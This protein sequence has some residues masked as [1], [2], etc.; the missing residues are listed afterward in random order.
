MNM[1]KLNYTVT[2]ETKPVPEQ[3]DLLFHFVTVTDHE[4]ET[5]NRREYLALTDSQPTGESQEMCV[6]DL[7]S[8]ALIGQPVFY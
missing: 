8:L 7:M 2:V 1:R 4:T 3:G 6:L 5:V